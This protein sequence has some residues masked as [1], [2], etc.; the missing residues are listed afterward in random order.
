EARKVCRQLG[1]ILPR[2]GRVVSVIADFTRGQG[3]GDVHGASLSILVNSNDGL[4]GARLAWRQIVEQIRNRITV[5]QFV[6]V[7]SQGAGRVYSNTVRLALHDEVVLAHADGYAL[8]RNA[9]VV[10]NTAGLAQSRDA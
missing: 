1:R 5:R 4:I 6:S 9:H 2:F 3:T 10:R 8:V 7:I